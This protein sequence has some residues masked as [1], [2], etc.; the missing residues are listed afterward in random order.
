MENVQLPDVGEDDLAQVYPGQAGFGAAGAVNDVDHI[1]LPSGSDSGGDEGVNLPDI[2]Q[3]CCSMSCYDA[4]LENQRLKLRVQELQEGLR[5]ARPHD[6][7][8][9]QFDCMRVWQTQDS[10]W[11]RFHAFNAEPL[12]QTSVQRLLGMG[13][14]KYSKYCQALADGYLE[15]PADL[16]H[17]Q[18]Q[19]D[20]GKL[21]SEA[22]SACHTLLAWLHET[23]AEHLAESDAFVQAKKSLAT[24]GSSGPSLLDQAQGPKMVK[25]LPP[26]TTMSEMRDF[27]LSFHPD[28]RAPSFATFVRVY[29][30][31]WQAWLKIR[32][33]K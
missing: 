1:S 26:G 4:L 9:L 12:C 11:R 7:N 17:T 29:H 19:R 20:L 23:I 10:G 5:D 30:S 3:P 21:A 22:T 24:S 28:L 32:A 31:E 27:A 6:R 13:K 25:W 8:K 14:G 18:H 15:P 33:E 2:S 16:R